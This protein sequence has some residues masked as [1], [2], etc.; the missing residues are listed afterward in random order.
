LAGPKIDASKIEVS[1]EDAMV[2]VEKNPQKDLQ[3]GSQKSSQKGSQNEVRKGV[4]DVVKNDA[5]V[6]STK[7][8]LAHEDD[9]NVKDGN[10]NKDEGGIAKLLKVI[11]SYKEANIEETAKLT[12]G[13]GK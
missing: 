13:K 4:Q 8:G 6:K 11:K 9:K 2:L 10:D 3:K 12:K 1:K 5:S 7:P